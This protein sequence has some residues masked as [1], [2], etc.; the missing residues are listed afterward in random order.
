MAHELFSGFIK[1]HILHHAGEGEV[2]GL[3]LI[4][5][6]AKHGYSISPGTLY[7]TLHSLEGA[8][9]LSSE[10][11]VVEGRQRRYYAITKAGTAALADARARLR[12]LADEV[13]EPG[14]P[15]TEAQ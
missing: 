12:E 8:G 9:Y 15:A 13:L 7:P 1:I 14:D 11:R 2:Y 4:E 10:K 3:W 5:E 6:L